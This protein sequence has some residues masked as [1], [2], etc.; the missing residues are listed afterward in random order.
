MK[1]INERFWRSEFARFVKSYGVDELAVQLDVQ[2]SAIYH[3]IRASTTP[4]LVHAETIQRLARERGEKL[5][6]DEIYGHFLSL[7]A[8]EV[9]CKPRSET[10]TSATRLGTRMF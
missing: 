9:A 3:W 2:P 7:R 6:M 8:A 1:Q 10:S 5:T 4:R